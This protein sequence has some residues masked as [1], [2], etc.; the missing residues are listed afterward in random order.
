MLLIHICFMIH[1]H[2]RQSSENRGSSFFIF[3]FILFYFIIFL[4]LPQ[5][6]NVLYMPASYFLPGLSYRNW[7]ML[8]LSC[9]LVY[10]LSYL[11]WKLWIHLVVNTIPIIECLI[12]FHV[13]FLSSYHTIIDRYSRLFLSS[14]SKPSINVY[15]TV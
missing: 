9:L 10:F 6:D 15:S 12:F 11:T 14:T 3:Y 13:H 7:A 4:P 8:S 2:C 5:S 1:K